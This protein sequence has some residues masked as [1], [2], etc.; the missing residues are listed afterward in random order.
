MKHTYRHIITRNSGPSPR[1]PRGGER[2]PLWLLLPL[3]LLCL[4]ACSSS[5][6]DQTPETP[7]VEQGKTSTQLYVY[8]HAP[9][10]AVPT[11]AESDDVDPIGNEAKVYSLQI[12]VFTHTS[13][14]LIG[15]YSPTETSALNQPG[16]SAIFQITI[17]EAYAQTAENSREHV[18]VY[19]LANVKEGNCHLTLDHTTTRAELEATVL[20]HGTTQDAFGL[21]TPVTTVPENLGLPMSGVLRDQPVTG[22]APVLRLD[23]GGQI[24]T[25]SLIRTVSKLRFAFAN[26]TG[27]ETLVINSIKLNA[28][29]I[30]EAQYLFMADGAPYNR[31]TCHIKTGS[32]YN[33]DASVL[34]AESIDN[35]PAI[36]QPVI[37]AW[38]NEELDPQAYE[39]MLDEAAAAGNL[40][41]RLYYLRESDKMLQ[42]EIKYQ[43][44][45]GGEQTA[46][47]QMVDEGGFS[48]NHIWTVYAYQALARLHVVVINIAPW[49]TA[50]TNYEFYNW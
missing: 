49:M 9:Q 19:V 30:P 10:T 47:F 18:D 12:W 38:G 36:D 23:N 33:T 4:T 11:R 42:G 40:T 1:S 41:Q 34:L 35:V 5:D 44:G 2:K 20:A 21:T 6:E 17:D 29:M 45:D 14:K 8:V 3:L 39:H 46:T 37:Y 25:V 24:A 26:Q 48:R 15:Y 27:N 28:D 43:I 31:K 32:G 7:I 16:G 13:N 22:T 50:E